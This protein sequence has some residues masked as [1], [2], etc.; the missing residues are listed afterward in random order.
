MFAGERRSL[1]QPPARPV[2]LAQMA[3]CAPFRIH[4]KPSLSFSLSLSVGH[5]H[6]SKTL[7]PYLYFQSSYYFYLKSSSQKLHNDYQ[8]LNPTSG[9][10]RRARPALALFAFVLRRP[11][12]RQRATVR[13]PMPSN[14]RES[15]AEF[16]I[17]VIRRRSPPSNSFRPAAAPTQF[18]YAQKKREEATRKPASGPKRN[19]NRMIN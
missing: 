14:F 9:R 7:I 3:G 6:S 2:Q 12:T 11:P 18:S 19:E 15:E 16:S 17:V 13:A 1:A 5:F 10:Q 4:S 8:A